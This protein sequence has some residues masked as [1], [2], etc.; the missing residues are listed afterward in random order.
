MPSAA[1][2]EIRP[3]LA[4]CDLVARDDEDEPLQQ[5]RRVKVTYCSSATG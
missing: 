2:K 5:A 3:R 4:M 1:L